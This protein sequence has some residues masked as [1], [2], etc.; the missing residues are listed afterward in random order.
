MNN[1]KSFSIRLF[2]W[3][4]Y[5]IGNELNVFDWIE[6]HGE[7]FF[8][9]DLSD[10]RRMMFVLRF[11]GEIVQRFFLLVTFLDLR[12]A[13]I[14]GERRRRLLDLS[15]SR[16]F[17]HLEEEK[18]RRGIIIELLGSDLFVSTAT[19]SRLTGMSSVHQ[20]EVDLVFLYSSS[21]KEF[22]ARYS[23]S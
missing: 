11:M 21:R 22:S 13:L 23:P 14:V 16:C 19:S 12:G 2:R 4:A 20:K 6:L 18:K 10:D 15:V 5:A 7:T 17:A 9:G 3:F 8:Q 1:Q